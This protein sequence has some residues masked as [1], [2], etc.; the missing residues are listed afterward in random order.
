[1]GLLAWF[2]AARLL[3]V[4]FPSWTETVRGAVGRLPEALVVVSGAVC[5]AVVVER[6]RRGRWP[7]LA[8]C[9]VSGSRPEAALRPVAVLGVVWLG[10][11]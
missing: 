2:R 11:W 5:G 1:M 9:L 3:G 10:W 7:E 8:S 6:E 4:G